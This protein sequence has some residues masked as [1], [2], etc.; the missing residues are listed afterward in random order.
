MP[1]RS[2]A[3][4]TLRAVARYRS[5]A[6]GA[7]R[8]AGRALDWCRQAFARDAFSRKKILFQNQKTRSE[9]FAVGRILE[10]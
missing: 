10:C 1:R 3:K 2:R 7:R 4:V 8:S 6:P 9:A 5:A